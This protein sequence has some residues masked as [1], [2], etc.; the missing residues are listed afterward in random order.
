MKE[1]VKSPIM[2]GFI[3]FVLGFT[4]ISSVQDANN[5]KKDLSHTNESSQIIYKK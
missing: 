3:I 2:M 5:T 4:Y 1:I